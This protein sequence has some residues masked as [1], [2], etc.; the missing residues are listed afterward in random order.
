L[1]SLNSWLLPQL[2]FL[3]ANISWAM[4]RGGPLSAEDF[5]DITLASSLNRRLSL[6]G[7]SRMICAREVVRA[8]AAVDPSRGAAVDPGPMRGIL[9]HHR[10]RR[11]EKALVLGKGVV[12]AVELEVT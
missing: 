6:T 4:V 12:E 5:P 2:T 1:S 7:A 8:E 3:C 9:V 11:K 10:A